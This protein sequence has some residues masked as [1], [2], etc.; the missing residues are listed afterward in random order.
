M[1]RDDHVWDDVIDAS[2]RQIYAAYARERRIGARSA[3]LAIDLYNIV[4]EG[5]SHPPEELVDRY[6]SS[7]GK[8]AWDAIPAIQRLLALAR[9]AKLP[10][11]YSTSESRA[12]A[13]PAGWATMRGGKRPDSSKFE[14]FEAFTP[15]P[16]DL[17]VRKQRASAFYGSPLAAFLVQRGIDS[18]IVC[19]ESTS[20]C[21]RASVVDAFSAG[22]H[23]TVVEECVFD[24]S[25]VSHKVN[26]WDIHQKY[27]DV[28]H[29]DEVEAQ[30]RERI[31]VA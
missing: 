6:P 3:L 27:G 23:V 20:G 25:P 10:I 13:Y 24:R 7:C 31:G 16:E 12:D 26:L 18:L 29:L 19:G 21:V 14:I 17:V 28:M 8:Y 11:A 30:L 15:K 9:E 2:T 1:T 4:F 5:G 22:F